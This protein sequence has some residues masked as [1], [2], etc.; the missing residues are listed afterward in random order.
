MPDTARR[1][2]RRVGRSGACRSVPTIDGFPTIGRSPCLYALLNPPRP[3]AKTRGGQPK[4]AVYSR[5]VVALLRHLPELQFHRIELPSLVEKADG[6]R[7]AEHHGREALARFGG[8]ALGFVHLSTVEQHRH[9]IGVLLRAGS[10]AVWTCL[11]TTKRAQT[12]RWRSRG[13]RL[14]AAPLRGVNG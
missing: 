6:R 4:D 14:F 2:S 5:Y 10:T 12:V 9:E 13:S 3:P 8:P 7:H 1:A 11:N